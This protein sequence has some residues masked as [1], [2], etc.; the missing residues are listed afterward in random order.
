MF[1]GETRSTQ[2]ANLGETCR[3][4]VELVLLSLA[5]LRPA[6]ALLSR[7][8][9]R[10]RSR[11]FNVAAFRALKQQKMGPETGV[12]LT[13][14]TDFFCVFGCVP[15]N[16][17]KASAQTDFIESSRACALL[18]NLKMQLSLIVSLTSSHETASR[19]RCQLQTKR[20]AQEQR[21]LLSSLKTLLRFWN[22]CFYFGSV[23]RNEVHGLF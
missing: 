21:V 23:R 10:L 12:L 18:H 1:G 7:W 17:S 11:S 8:E 5:A 19:T 4:N 20:R 2:M 15:L 16:Q 13:R 9:A 3:E 6:A 22:G 14:W